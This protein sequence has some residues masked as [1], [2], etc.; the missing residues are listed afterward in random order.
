[1]VRSYIDEKY[2][3]HYFRSLLGSE[4]FSEK[5][6]QLEQIWSFFKSKSDLFFDKELSSFLENVDPPLRNVILPLI[7]QL[8]TGRQNTIIYQNEKNTFRNLKNI[9]IYSKLNYPFATFWLGNQY[10]YTPEKYKENNPYH[11]LT[12]ENDMDEWK[13]YSNSRTFYVNPKKT[14]HGNDI[15]KS[16]GQ[17]KRFHH[18]P[19]DLIINDKFCLKSDVGIRENI[20][21]IVENLSPQVKNFIIFI[22]IP[23]PKDR[24]N[25]NQTYDLL[26]SLFKERGLNPN[27]L[28]F[29]SAKTHHDRFILTNSFLIKSGDSFDYFNAK[30]T[31]KTRGTTLSITPVFN[32][33]KTEIQEYISLHREIMR[34]AHTPYAGT[35][36]KNLLDLF[37]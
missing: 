12:N 6:N 14:Q 4:R 18:Y 33:N 11:F 36:S 35:K 20:V 2:L 37:N 21:P 7:N 27:I 34:S 28:I 24:F 31:F 10:N 23:E 17:L 13:S 3:E 16:W 8:T 22:G 15:L 1:M 29:I 5:S 26:V 32:S 30:N 19:H 25:L 9:N